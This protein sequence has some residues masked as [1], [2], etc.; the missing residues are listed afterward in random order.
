MPFSIESGKIPLIALEDI[1]HYVLWLLDNPS[2]SSGL[3]LEIA[4][5]QVNFA[6]I[7][8]TFT[9]VTG[10]KGMHQYVPLEKYLDEAEP[11]PNAPANWAAGPGVTRDESTMTWKE[12]F[13]AWWRFWGEGLGATRDLQKLTTIHPSRIKSL[14]EWMVKVHYDGKRK[15]V[16]KG[17]E[18]LRRRA[19]PQ[20]QGNI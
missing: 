9:T 2:L 10:K 3:N 7:A 20:K 8:R 11:Y 17:A 13:G 18:D 19:T 14:E 1:G 12:N 6:D 16:L 4:T 5:D 15:D